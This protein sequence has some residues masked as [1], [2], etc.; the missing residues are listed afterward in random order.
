MKIKKPK[1][2]TAAAIC[3]CSWL[4]LWIPII[5]F[6]DLHDDDYAPLHGIQYFL[7]Y[8]V[9][10]GAVPIWFVSMLI[11]GYLTPNKAGGTKDD[12]YRQM[13]LCSF[14]MSLVLLCVA[15]AIKKMILSTIFLNLLFLVPLIGS[16]MYDGGYKGK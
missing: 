10:C 5:G 6:A 9:T 1:A 14:S 7:F 2:D 4:A 12:A 8:A 13:G 16:K 3:G 15:I 11:W